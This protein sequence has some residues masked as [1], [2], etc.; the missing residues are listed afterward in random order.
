MQLTDR[1]IEFLTRLIGNH[2]TDTEQFT[3]K[4][5]CKLA[6]HAEFRGIRNKKPLPIKTIHFES[7]G[8][9]VMVQVEEGWNNE[10]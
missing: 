10:T 6:D 7:Y 8:N 4:L 1:E 5:Y 9:R 2:V 3:Y